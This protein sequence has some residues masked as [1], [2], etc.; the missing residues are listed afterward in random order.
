MKVSRAWLQKYFD[1]EL[2]HGQE[3][4]DAFTFH[5]F[6]VEE[7]A[8]DLIDLKVLPDRAGY[9]LSHRGIASELSAALNL[10]LKRDPLREPVAMKDLRSPSLTIRLEDPKKCQ[11]YMGAV[12]K[13]VKVGP[14][15]DWLKRALESVGQRSIN[16][17]VDAT[18]YVMLDLGQPL[19]AFDAGKIAQ[20]DGAY[21]ISVRMAKEG[22]RIATLSDDEYELTPDIQL[23]TDGNSGAPLGIAGIKGGN[24]AEVGAGTTDL[25]IESANFE[26]ATTRKAS[27]RLKLSTDASLRF[28]NRPSPELCAYGMRDVLKLI[29]DIAGGEAVS[30]IDE[31][32]AKAEPSPVGTTRDRVN[33]LLGSEFSADEIAGVFARLG[34]ETERDGDSFKVMPP[35]E[36]TDIRIPQDL[37]EEVGRIMGYDRIA[38]TELP[39]AGEGDQARYRGIERMKDQLVEQGFIEVSTQSFAKE[40][41]VYLANPL[42][43]AKPALRTSLEE[44]LKDALTR[45][46]LNAP[47]VLPPKQSPKLFEVGSVF[48]EGG[49]YLELRMTEPAWDGVPAHDNLTL[50]KLEEYGKGYEPKQY[51]LGAYRPFS[52][53]PFIARDISMWI[54]DTDV[55]RGK[56]LEAFAKEGSGLIR[57][58]QLLDQFAN[59]EGRQSLAFRLVFQSFDRT[60]TDEEVNGIMAS[61]SSR[62]EELGYEIR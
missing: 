60:L 2:P 16:N 51:V 38:A 10:P 37:A 15:P 49:E 47:L 40:G 31:Y 11:R 5:S 24:A 53:Y 30:V 41:D 8:G 23:I 12:V 56:I 61:I 57:Q 14:S 28:Q 6:E 44:N 21:A 19:H 62:I 20:E 59:K 35:F 34:F 13:G 54:I 26:G 18:N 50:A 29:T 36:R 7:E 52:A 4:S 46:K 43:K 42:D 55:A 45:A 1:A 58:V 48:P 32:P 9:A 27:Q 39:D 33:G 22:E 3:L 17:V 25:I